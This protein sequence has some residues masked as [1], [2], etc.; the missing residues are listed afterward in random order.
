MKYAGWLLADAVFDL[1]KQK[2][3]FVVDYTIPP[4][5]GYFKVDADILYVVRERYIGKGILQLIAAAKMRK[6]V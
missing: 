5:N 6:E 2:I 4:D 3:K 1:Q